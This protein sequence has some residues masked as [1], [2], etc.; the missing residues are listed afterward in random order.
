MCAGKAEAGFAAS[1]QQAL[2]QLHSVVA[3]QGSREGDDK[4]ATENAI[5]AI[6]RICKHHAASVDTTQVCTSPKVFILSFC[7]SQFPH[8]S[9]NLSFITTY[10]QDTLNRP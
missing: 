2:G 6:A 4:E 5:D 7:K 8:K 1:A 3:A 10:I 9:V